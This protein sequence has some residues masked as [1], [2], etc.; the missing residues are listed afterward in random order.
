MSLLTV[1]P[2]GIP[3]FLG[4]PRHLFKIGAGWPL[5]IACY[6]RVTDHNGG[7]LANRVAPITIA[8]ISR[9]WTGG[10]LAPRTVRRQLQHLDREGYIELTTLPGVGIA[11]RVLFAVRRLGS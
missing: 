5:L 2:I 3:E 1:V 7:V 9:K 11:I 8:E 6:R 10:G 4:G